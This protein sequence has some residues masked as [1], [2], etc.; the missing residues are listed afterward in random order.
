[1]NSLVRYLGKVKTPEARDVVVQYLDTPSRG[2]AVRALVQM[3]ATGVR[4]LIEPLAEDRHP[5]I[6]KIARTALE[7]LS[8]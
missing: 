6:R 8:D 4:R 7:K 1:M 3:K 2:E 5:P